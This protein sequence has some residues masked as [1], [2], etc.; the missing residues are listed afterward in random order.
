VFWVNGDVGVLTYAYLYPDGS[1][2]LA[3]DMRTADEAKQCVHDASTPGVRDGS[4]FTWSKTDRTVVIQEHNHDGSTPMTF[5]RAITQVNGNTTVGVEVSYPVGTA[6]PPV[7]L[8]LLTKAVTDSAE[9]AKIA[10][11]S[12]GSGTPSP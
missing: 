3:E 5:D 4:D 6:D 12:A 11:P 8:D 10:T 9:L 1:D 2:E 7:A